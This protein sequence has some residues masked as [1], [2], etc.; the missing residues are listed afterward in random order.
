MRPRVVRDRVTFGALAAHCLRPTRGKA[1][2]STA[3]TRL[4]P[5]TSAAHSAAA[6]APATRSRE[7]PKLVIPV[8]AAQRP[9]AGIHDH[10]FR[11]S[12][13]LW[14]WVPATGHPVAPA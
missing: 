11:N 9:R 13:A 3:R 5:S 12:H 7:I 14:S 8:K 10:Q 2:G 6:G 1:A 4:V